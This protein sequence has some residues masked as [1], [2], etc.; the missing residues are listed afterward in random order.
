MA[1]GGKSLGC[2]E[3][4]VRRLA[5]EPGAAQRQLRDFDAEHYV[6]R[7]APLALGEI[8][9]LPVPG[10]LELGPSRE[11]ELHATPG[12]T[13]DGVAYWLPWLR[14]LVCGDYISP[15]EIPML[16]ES[17]SLDAY[18]LTLARLRELLGAGD[19]G[20]PGPRRADRVKAGAED[21][22]RGRPLPRT[23]RAR[24]GQGGTPEIPP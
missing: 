10:S 2:A 20:D 11:L 14:V 7:H 1:F 5:A 9:S 16:S 6:E 17:G 24:S 21:P 15:V 8:Q 23:A 4:T 19:L 3:S 18:S 12:H 22:R 13:A